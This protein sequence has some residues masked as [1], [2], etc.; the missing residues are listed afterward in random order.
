M[1]RRGRALVALA[2]GALV[3]TGDAALAQH[4]ELVRAPE[5]T[6]P[7]FEP[8]EPITPLGAE[9]ED[10]ASLPVHAEE[11][12]QTTIRARLDEEKHAVTGATTVQIGRAHV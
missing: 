11:V 12:H 9:L 3:T 7:S 1:A 4:A 5:I 2:L 8:D 6:W 10:D